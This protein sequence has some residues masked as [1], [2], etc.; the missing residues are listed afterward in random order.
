M[1]VRS[2]SHV[3]DIDFADMTTCVPSCKGC[4]GEPVW[5]IQARLRRDE[6]PGAGARVRRSRLD[7]GH[8]PSNGKVRIGPP[9]VMGKSSADSASLADGSCASLYPRSAQISESVSDELALWT[10][11]YFATIES[12]SGK[13]LV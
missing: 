4:D 6:G 11:Q 5:R 10:L 2:N 12:F 13:D 8:Q 9:N 7:S 3:I 1:A